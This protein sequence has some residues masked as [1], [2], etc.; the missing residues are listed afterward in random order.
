MAVWALAWWPRFGAC[1]PGVRAVAGA[2]HL[3]AS[4][5]VLQARVRVKGRHTRAPLAGAGVRGLREKWPWL[6]SWLCPLIKMCAWVHT[7]CVLPSV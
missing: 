5:Q 3:R 7:Q 1:A 2:L 6:V 4:R